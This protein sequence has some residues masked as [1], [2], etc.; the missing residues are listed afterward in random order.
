[1]AK[2][3][4]GEPLHEIYSSIKK[5]ND[6]SDWMRPIWGF[7][8]RQQGQIREARVMENWRSDVSAYEAWAVCQIIRRKFELFGRIFCDALDQKNSKKILKI[9]CLKTCLFFCYFSSFIVI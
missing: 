5:M 4:E 9:K 7:L 2:G 6:T 1:M 3:R 8:L